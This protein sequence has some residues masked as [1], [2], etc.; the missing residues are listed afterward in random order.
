MLEQCDASWLPRT[1]DKVGRP[2]HF[3]SNLF[4]IVQSYECVDA[5]PRGL[6]TILL[7]Y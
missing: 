3:H 4:T 7:L 5:V 2:V 6:A 1:A